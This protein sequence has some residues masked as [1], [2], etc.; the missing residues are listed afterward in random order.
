MEDLKD[1]KEEGEEVSQEGIRAEEAANGGTSVRNTLQAS[2]WY[3]RK[4]KA[5]ATRKNIRV[6][7]EDFSV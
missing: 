1:R 2:P 4:I 3:R 5:V 6:Y 7:F